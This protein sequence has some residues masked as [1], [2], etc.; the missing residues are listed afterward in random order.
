MSEVTTQLPPWTVMIKY[1]R[2]LQTTPIFFVTDIDVDTEEEAIA[3]VLSLGY[4][5]PKATFELTARRVPVLP[6]I[7]E[8]AETHAPTN[9]PIRVKETGAR[10]VVRTQTSRK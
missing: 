10:I 2:K 6:K 1:L 9:E 5:L 4:C 8:K 7:E 3:H